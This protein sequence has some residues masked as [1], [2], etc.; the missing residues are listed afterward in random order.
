MFGKASEEKQREIIRLMEE[1]NRHLRAL[2]APK[3][4]P[5]DKDGRLIITGVDQKRARLAEK[6]QVEKAAAA[7]LDTETSEENKDKWRKWEEGK[8]TKK[9]KSSAGGGPIIP[10]AV[11]KQ[12]KEVGLLKG[13][14]D[15][16]RWWVGLKQDTWPD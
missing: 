14:F 13:A 10:C 15:Q 9:E 2:R 5:R 16:F 8:R 6:A 12:G 3:G 1:Q 4:L 11:N 7:A